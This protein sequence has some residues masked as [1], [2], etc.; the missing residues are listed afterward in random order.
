MPD[1]LKVCADPAYLPFSD[2]AGD[3]FEN[4]IARAIGGY[5]NE[6]VEYTWRSYRGNGGF[7][8]FLAQTLNAHRCD[9]VM[10][11]PYGS[12]EAFTTDPYYVSSYV[13][14]LR[15]DKPVPNERALG[16]P[17]RYSFPMSMAVRS[18]DQALAERL[19]AVIR[20][21]KEALVDILEHHGVRLYR[22]SVGP[23][24]LNQM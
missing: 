9:L 20:D 7:E 16:S 14:V 19:N 12:G 24:G 1:T 13:F 8:E 23:N 3:G 5:L 17:E 2:R 10:D 11:L 6:P 18:D 22:P 15:R 4:A 21:H